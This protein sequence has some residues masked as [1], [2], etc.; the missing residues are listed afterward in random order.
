MRNL[1][2]NFGC[3]ID[4]SQKKNEKKLGLIKILKNV[5]PKLE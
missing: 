1:D 5:R 2:D 4:F 3:Q